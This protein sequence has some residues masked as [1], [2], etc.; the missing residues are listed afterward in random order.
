MLRKIFGAIHD[1]HNRMKFAFCR[2]KLGVSETH[3]EHYWVQVSAMEI[4]KFTGETDTFIVLEEC[5]CKARRI[6]LVH[7]KMWFAYLM[8]SSI[9]LMWETHL[10]STDELA[11]IM[12]NP[13]ITD[14]SVQELTKDRVIRY[15]DA[16]NDRAVAIREMLIKRE[17]E[18]VDQVH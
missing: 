6:R 7:K 3:V 17:Q 18:K 12:T 1:I 16:I 5:S 4:T 8:A 9:W 14:E 2:D 10:V 11:E 13:N 15:P